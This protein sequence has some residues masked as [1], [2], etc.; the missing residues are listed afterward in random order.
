MVTVEQK[1]KTKKVVLL[2]RVPVDDDVLVLCLCL[3][4]WWISSR[5]LLL[6]VNPCISELLCPCGCFS[7]PHSLFMSL[8]LRLFPMSFFSF[9]FSRSPSLSLRGH[10]PL[11]CREACRV[12][13][14]CFRK[15][16]EKKCRS[17]RAKNKVSN[18]ICCVSGPGLGINRP[19]RKRQREVSDKKDTCMQE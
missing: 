9:G 6:Y 8:S 14:I 3:S 7:L 5:T 1:T 10:P 12:V 2:L 11:W 16:K 17:V 19:K 4:A 18:W 15:P 13:L